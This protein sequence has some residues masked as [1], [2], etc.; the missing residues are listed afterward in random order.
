MSTQQVNTTN[1]KKTRQRS[2]EVAEKTASI[3]TSNSQPKWMRKAADV[4]RTKKYAIL[5]ETTKNA[6]IIY[7]TVQPILLSLFA[8][9]SMEKVT[10]LNNRIQY[11]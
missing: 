2:L 3:S 5:S 8:D 10:F 4:I 6:N 11:H 9:G 1:F 7:Q